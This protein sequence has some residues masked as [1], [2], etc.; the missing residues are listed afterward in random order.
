MCHLLYVCLVVFSA[1]ELLKTAIENAGFTDK[2]VIGMDVAASEFYRE[3]KYDLDFKSPP[4]SSRH[5]TGDELAEIYQSFVND[6]PGSYELQL[7]LTGR[8]LALCPM[9]GDWIS[10]FDLDKV[11]FPPQ[12]LQSHYGSTTL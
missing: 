6:Y 2:I 10:S 3:G 4:D 5:I 11:T 12:S 9:T 7:N 1:L 8:L